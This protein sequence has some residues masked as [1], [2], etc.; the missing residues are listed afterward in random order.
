MLRWIVV[1]LEK[2]NHEPVIR[3]EIRRYIQLALKTI[4]Q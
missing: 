3:K 1:R 4:F 2:L